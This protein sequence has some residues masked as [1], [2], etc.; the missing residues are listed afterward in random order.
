MKANVNE[1]GFYRVNYEA[2]NWMALTQHLM[3]NPNSTVSGPGLA[4]VA[5]GHSKKDL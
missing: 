1:T 5:Y 4:L 3:E 2:D